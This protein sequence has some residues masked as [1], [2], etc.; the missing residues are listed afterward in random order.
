[1]GEGA[2]EMTFDCVRSVHCRSNKDQSPKYQVKRKSLGLC[3]VSHI[4]KMQFLILCRNGEKGDIHYG[5]EKNILFTWVLSFFMQIR[6][7]E[8]FVSN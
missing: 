8:H 7:R 3:P 6:H 1:M 4:I 2:I 5:R